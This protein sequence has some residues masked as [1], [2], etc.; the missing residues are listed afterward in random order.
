MAKS[1]VNPAVGDSGIVPFAVVSGLHG[2]YLWASTSS[3]IPCWCVVEKTETNS[4]SSL[5]VI[6]GHE[7][8]LLKRIEEADRDAERI[9]AAARLD[10]AR[11]AEEGAETL[12]AELAR[13]RAE[14]EAQREAERAAKQKQADEKLE[15][16]RIEARALTPEAVRNVIALVLP[17]S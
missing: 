4:R 5:A 12:A 13:I 17:R 16:M 11:I 7:R 8:E 15:Q 9:R 14:G 1:L 3:I 2:A 10:S 6:A